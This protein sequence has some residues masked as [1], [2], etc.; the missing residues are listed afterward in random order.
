MS[1]WRS[2]IAGDDPPVVEPDGDR[3]VALLDRLVRLEQRIDQVIGRSAGADAFQ[4]RPD[5]TAGPGDGV[6][7]QAER[8]LAAKDRLAPRGV[9][10]AQSPGG[11][12]GGLLGRERPGGLLQGRGP[13]ERL[14]QGRI[15]ASRRP[16]GTDGHL[17][18]VLGQRL[19][20]Q[21]RHQGRRPRLDLGEPT[22]DRRDA[23]SSR[24]R[25]EVSEPGGRADGAR[26]GIERGQGG[27]R[28]RLGRGGASGAASRSIAWRLA[29]SPNRARPSIAARRSASARIGRPGECGEP[30]A[31]RLHFPEP[32]RTCGGGPQRLVLAIEGSGRA[33]R[34]RPPAGPSAARSPSSGPRARPFAPRWAARCRGTGP[35]RRQPQGRRAG[36]AS[37]W[38]SAPPLPGRRARAPRGASPAAAGPRRACSTAWSAKTRC[39]GLP[40]KSNRPAATAG[41]HSGCRSRGRQPEGVVE[42]PV[43]RPV[44]RPQRQLGRARAGNL[45]QGPHRLEPDAG[46]SSTTRWPSSADRVGDPAVPVRHD[47]HAPP[48]GPAGRGA[49][50]RLAQ[51]LRL[52]DVERLVG[53]EGFEPR[54]ARPRGPAGR[55]P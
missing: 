45:R 33:G 27:D 6:A 36:P 37:R 30:R 4:A 40:P 41:S 18:D 3:V 24:P 25:P 39:R 12:G 26:P 31:E 53:P 49:S 16:A 50:S 38:R 22:D 32:G 51:Q 35:G 28:P 21:G 14:D 9:A 29:R 11:Q 55:A 52:D 47:P 15:F 13:A 20:G 42:E 48:P 2:L 19:A 23:P 44:Q 17:G 8:L 43:D 34:G 46:M 10:L 5:L 54:G 1:V 7:L